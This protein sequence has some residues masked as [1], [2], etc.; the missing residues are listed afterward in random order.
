M[1]KVCRVI[2]FTGDGSGP[3]L[4]FVSDTDVKK[5]GDVVIYEG[6]NDV[7]RAT[8]G[9]GHLTNPNWKKVIASSVSLSINQE[10]VVGGVFFT[11]KEP[12]SVSCVPQIPLSFIKRFAE[13]GG[14][15]DEVM[16]E[17]VTQ[18]PAFKPDSLNGGYRKTSNIS[19]PPKLKLT[20]NKEVIVA[21]D[22]IGPY[23]STSL[24]RDIET[25]IHQGTIESNKT[26]YLNDFTNAF[27]PTPE[28]RWLRV[29]HSKTLQQKWV[30][31]NGSV[32]WRNVPIEESY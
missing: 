3:A 19:I 16:V 27:S 23:G 1:N 21:S 22:N 29:M 8:P 14:R 17:C 13:S 2:S 25:P 6:D 12:A 4:V 24:K 9:H 5:A 11:N 15:I 18:I 30:T 7:R 26:L 31:Q 28:L 32:E 10:M 20:N